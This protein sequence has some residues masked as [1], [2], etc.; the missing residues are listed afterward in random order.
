[1][2]LELEYH[3]SEFQQ[4]EFCQLN[5]I[6]ERECSLLSRK[7]HPMYSRVC[8]YVGN[9]WWCGSAHS[10]FQA[11]K[12]WAFGFRAFS[13]L[14]FSDVNGMKKIEHFPG[15]PHEQTFQSVF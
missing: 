1:M 8:W 5:Q 9:H 15:K 10:E 14:V 6:R 11:P 12:S 3:L 4:S 13:N 7:I 2:R